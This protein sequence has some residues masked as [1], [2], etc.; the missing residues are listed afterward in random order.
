VELARTLS[1]TLEEGCP[2]ARASF[3]EAENHA[4]HLELHET[5]IRR[6]ARRWRAGA[7]AEGRPLV[8]VCLLHHERPADLV[9]AVASIERQTWPKVE[10][11]VVDNGSRSEEAL[12]TL[13]R[14]EQEFAP[15]EWRIVRLAENM[16]EPHARNLGAAEGRGKYVLFMDDDN[17]AKP[18][19][20]EVFAGVAERTG[21]QVLTCF[22][23]H[24]DAPDPP[25]EESQAL[26]RFIPIGDAG[27]IGLNFN[28][29]GDVNCFVDRKA[30]LDIGGFVEDLRF[31]HAEDWRFLAKAHACG[32]SMSVVPEALVWYRTFTQPYALSWRKRDRSGGLMRAAE[33]YFAAAPA[34]VRP[35]VLLAQG[36]F[37]KAHENEQKLRE[38][39]AEHRS[40]KAQLRTASDELARLEGRYRHLLVEYARLAEAGQHLMDE[41]IAPSPMAR[42]MV[43]AARLGARVHFG[44][45]EPPG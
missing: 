39:T 36:L 33:A 42:R 34:E 1:R 44:L 5:T 14:L 32:L 37:W 13:A 31:N 23:D 10:L 41:I 20:V 9:K 17:I 28:A 18:T 43:D 29:Y 7:R 3:G 45:P 38:T 15:R 26:K 19:E 11:V 22:L 8:T 30:F 16:Y 24:F 25:A 4:R 21:T 2:P 12:L 35:F 6:L 40:V 27:P